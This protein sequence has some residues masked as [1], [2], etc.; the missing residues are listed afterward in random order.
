[1]E[2]VV[3]YDRIR[4][5]ST[6]QPLGGGL[7]TALGKYGEYCAQFN[8]SLSGTGSR[9]VTGFTAIPTVTKHRV[10]NQKIIMAMTA[11]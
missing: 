9:G 7:Y 10:A 1:M 2:N 3:V 5:W 11:E 6:S 4:T 8:C